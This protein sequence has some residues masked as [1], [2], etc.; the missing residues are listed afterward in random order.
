MTAFRDFCC[1]PKG[2][3][4]HKSRCGYFLP[5][6]GA[7]IVRM[8]RVFALQGKK[9]LH[10][11]TIKARKRASP[12]KKQRLRNSDPKVCNCVQKHTY[13]VQYE[14]YLKLISHNAQTYLIF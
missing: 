1:N 4:S 8:W 7:L 13:H 10:I 3:A 6:C 9:T 2:R 5:A 12:G 11:L 14:Q